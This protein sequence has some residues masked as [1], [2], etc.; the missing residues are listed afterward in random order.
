MTTLTATF[1]LVDRV[2]IMSEDGLAIPKRIN[3]VLGECNPK[4]ADPIQNYLKKDGYYILG[5]V[6]TSDQLTALLSKQPIDLL[7]LG[8]L[9]GENCFAVFRDFRKR[10]PMLPVILISHQ[11]VSDVFRDWVIQRGLNDIFYSHPEHFSALSRSIVRNIEIGVMPHP[12]SV[13]TLSIESTNQ[14]TELEPLNDH[15]T[16]L[17]GEMVQAALMELNQLS[18]QYFGTLAI[19]HYWR[20]AHQKAVV[21]YTELEAWAV[22]Y[23][24]NFTVGLASSSILNPR[25][26]QGIQTWIQF[27]FQECQRIITDFPTLIKKV[28]TSRILSQ[29]LHPQ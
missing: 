19:G 6:S 3:L 28:S 25:E 15:S 23:Q 18:S 2:Q 24:G 22:D 11:P 9:K 4:I 7:L 8:E 29:L 1:D 20:K 21:E 13:A 16:D 10:W 17:S 14:A 5:R 26:I 27:F 12:I